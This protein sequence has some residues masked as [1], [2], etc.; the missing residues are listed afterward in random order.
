MDILT[1]KNYMLEVIDELKGQGPGMFQQGTILHTVKEKLGIQKN[2]EIEQMILTVW[3]DLIQTGYVSWGY[4]LSN[5]NPPFVHLTK[6]GNKALEQFS[7]DPSNIMGYMKYLNEHA[8]I[9]EIAHSYLDEAL[10]SFN[11]GCYK[12]TAVMIG[13]AS[14]SLI[15]QLRDS[16][17]N[18]L[19]NNQKTVPSKLSDW[20]IKTVITEIEKFLELNK[21]DMPQEL[22]EAYESFWKAFTGQIRISRNEAGH[23][24]S[25]DKITFEIVHSVLLLFPELALLI[26]KLE[27]WIN[28]L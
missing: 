1:V 28:S 25:I 21:K 27:D 20:R 14:E 16:I 13:C 2:I 15:L 22:K 26:Q 4:D 17:I 19:T 12:A 9:N 23:P 7:R 24:I 18:Y 8:Q 10:T 5:P 6:K 3:N 11:Y